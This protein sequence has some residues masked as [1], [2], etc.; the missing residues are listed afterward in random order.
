RGCGDRSLRAPGLH[1]VCAGPRAG[2]D[3]A[4]NERPDVAAV[5]G[6]RVAME[7][8]AGRRDQASGILRGRVRMRYGDTLPIRAGRIG[9]VPGRIDDPAHALPVVERARVT[10]DLIDLPR[11][12]GADHVQPLAETMP[13]REREA[14]ILAVSLLGHTGRGSDLEPLELAIQHE[15]DDA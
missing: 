5:L 8:E 4:L 12:D 6:E 11:L 1:A 2:R 14:E 9:R 3:V 15:V 10:V 13:A 7:R